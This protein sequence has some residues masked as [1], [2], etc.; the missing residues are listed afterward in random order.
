MLMCLYLI[1]INFAEGI[2]TPYS[3]VLRILKFR[4]FVW[5]GDAMSLSGDRLMVEC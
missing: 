4:L 2:P 5:W 3:D 1:D